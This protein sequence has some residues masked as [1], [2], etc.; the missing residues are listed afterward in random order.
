MTHPGNLPERPP[1]AAAAQQSYSY[2]EVTAAVE[3]KILLFQ[4]LAHGLPEWAD[5]GQCKWFAHGA[6]EVWKRLTY[7][8]QA[9]GDA[10]R[11]EALVN[12]I[13]PDID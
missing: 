9:P 13:R 11:L 7:G 3:E 1:Q 10:A 5:K 12:A 2:A 8:K 4:R 6:I